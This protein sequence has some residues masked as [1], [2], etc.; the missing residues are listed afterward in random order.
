MA[1]TPHQT[2][3]D[4]NSV[5]Q[6]DS[7]PGHPLFDTR[8][9]LHSQVQRM[10]NYPTLMQFVRRCPVGAREDWRQAATFL[11][12]YVGQASTYAHY[13]GVLQ[14]FLNYLWCIAEKTLRK[15]DRADI[16]GFL[17]FCHTPPAAWQSTARFA[18]FRGGAEDRWGNSDWRP[19]LCTSQQ[20]QVATHNGTKVIVKT[21]LL[22]LSHNGYLN[23]LPEPLLPKG[24]R[25]T[26]R[27]PNAAINTLTD[28]QWAF[29]VKHLEKMAAECPKM[30]RTLVA[31]MLLKSLFL[32]VSDLARVPRSG[33]GD[34]R[35]PMMSDFISRTLQGRTIW[36]L[37]IEGQRGRLR[38]I[39][40]PADIWPFIMRYRRWL[41]LPAQPS[42]HETM[43]ILCGK[44]QT[45]L[46]KRQLEIMVHTA[47]TS[48]AK[49]LETQGR[50]QEAG[51][52]RALAGRTDCLRHTGASQALAV[53]CPVHQLS[54]W[55][56]HH[57]I[58]Q[59]I[60]TYRVTGYRD[61][62]PP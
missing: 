23:K 25:L 11:L 42:P 59:T 49:A 38:W 47:M 1:K 22:H 13:R 35:Y 61:I 10:R 2:V 56:G 18:C 29:L 7:F 48:A 46:S 31:V 14:R 44:Q 60:N 51:K 39:P 19:F 21:F 32:R 36:F 41:D 27:S 5:T 53:G 50:W 3:I 52:F 40:V 20:R 30:E 28:P 12:H 37:R 17:R 24:P 57:S 4:W 45:A 9:H 33:S 55:M 16:E 43:P 54:R 26:S 58:D 62:C 6:R 15:A 8:V 34:D